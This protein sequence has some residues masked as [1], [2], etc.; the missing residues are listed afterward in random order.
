MSGLEQL[1]DPVMAGGAVRIAILG[2]DDVGSTLA[3]LG[4]AAG[5]DVTFAARHAARPRALAAELE[6]RAHA[7]SVTDAAAAAQAVLVAV[8]APAATAMLQAAGPLDGCVMIEQR[9]H[10]FVVSS[11]PYNTHAGNGNRHASC[12]T[13]PHPAV[14]LIQRGGAPDIPECQRTESYEFP[15]VRSSAWDRGRAGVGY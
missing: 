13:H 8:P 10:I 7:A 2:A 6:E 4:H 1:A 12:R 3:R 14:P 5:H 11:I 9:S 15:Q